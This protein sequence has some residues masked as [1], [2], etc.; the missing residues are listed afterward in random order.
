M[1]STIEVPSTPSSRVLIHTTAS[2][3]WALPTG[4]ATVSTAFH[5]VTGAFSSSSRAPGVGIT[6]NS[7][8]VGAAVIDPSRR[9]TASS[10]PVIRS[11]PH[12]QCAPTRAISVAS[13]S[14]STPVTRNC[15]PP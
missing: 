7:A 9:Y 14:P 13:T 11:G 8:C 5:E 1:R 2:T 12:R 4:G 10:R 6:P 15:A 3:P